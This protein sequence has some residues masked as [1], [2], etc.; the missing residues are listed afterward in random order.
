MIASRRVATRSNA[1][2]C[3]FSLGKRPTRDER[4]VLTYQFTVSSQRLRRRGSNQIAVLCPRFIISRWYEHASFVSGTVPLL[5]GE[6][7]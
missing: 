7:E 2:I 6:R 4:H 1:A 3:R 5:V